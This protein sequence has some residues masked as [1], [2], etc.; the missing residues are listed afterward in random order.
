MEKLSVIGMDSV[1]NS[2]LAELM[3]MESVQLRSPSEFAPKEAEGA[4]EGSGQRTEKIAEL[5]SKINDAELALAMLGKYSGAKSPLFATRRILHRDDLAQVMEERRKIEGDVNTVLGINLMLHRLREKKNKRMTE[6]SAVRPWMNYDLPLELEGTKMCDITLGV[7]PSAVDMSALTEEVLK[8]SE[9]ADLKEVNRDK[10]LIYVAM[11][12]LKGETEGALEVLRQS[13]FMESKFKGLHGKPDECEKFLEKS[14]E[15]LD[16]GISKAEKDI[17]AKYG[18]R[19]GIECLHDQ[20]VIERDREKARENLLSTRRTFSLEGWIPEVC[21]KKAVRVLTKYGC[22]FEF[23]DPEEGEEPPVVLK[24]RSMAY[25]FESITEMYSLPAYGTVDPTGIMAPFYAVFFG[26][27][28]SD[29]G[30]GIILTLATYIILKKF[31]LEGMTYRM[32]KMFFYCGI[33]T[34]FWGAMFGGWFGDFVTVASRTFLGKEITIDP[35]WFNPLD[36]PIT[37]LI[38]SIA[39]GIVH[40]F[41]GMG[42]QASELIKSGHKWDAVFD[43]F[44]WYMVITGLV[45]WMGGSQVSQALVKPGMYVTIAGAA[46]LLL[47]GGR[48]KKG[49]GK[50]TGG[51]GALYN[52]TSYASDILS[53]SRLLAL[54]LAT[55]VIAQVVNTVGTLAGGGVKGAIIMVLAFFIG[56]TFNLA[57]NALGAFV[58]TSR[59]QYIEFF[60]KFYEDGG[61]EFTPLRRNTKYIKLSDDTDGGVRK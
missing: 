50:I 33:S 9:R 30:Y 53:Y 24:N 13:G 20:L 29:A 38:F 57:I 39:L 21:I 55:G 7:L 44:S 27:M 59:L 56:H 61:E 15:K 34:V 49:I 23:N 48:K 5:E 43:I 12:T 47:T 25:P 28:L 42:I 45:M 19:E 54:G 10:D 31:N 3:D 1:K 16:E 46:I 8:K 37:L 4:E 26:M 40:L 14:I 41:I 22:W 35:V 6:L 18:Y 2:L 36:D 11:L 32:M 58:H 51:L 60:G 17:A 52:V